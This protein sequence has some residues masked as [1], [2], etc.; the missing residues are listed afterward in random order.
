M[1]LTGGIAGL[2]DGHSQGGRLQRHLGN[3]RRASTG[4]R[5]DRSTQRIAI[6][7]KLIKI[8]CATWVLGD[9]PVTGRRAECLHIHLQEEVVERRIRWGPPQFKP[10]RLG[11][12]AMVTASKQLQIPQALVAAQDPQHRHG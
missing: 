6:T 7:H 9:R 3:E 1:V 8:H 11:E 12:H 10:K 4:R 2:D 5:H